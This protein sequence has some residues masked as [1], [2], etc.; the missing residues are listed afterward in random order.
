MTTYI[1][2][3]L[4]MG[5]YST[6]LYH[7]GRSDYACCLSGL[8]TL[9]LLFLC[10][11]ASVSILA[12]TFSKEVFTLTE[13]TYQFDQ[14]QYI[15][16]T[17]YELE[18]RGLKPLL[19]RTAPVVEE[20]FERMKCSDLRVTVEFIEDFTK[21]P[22]FNLSNIPFKQGVLMNQSYCYFDISSEDVDFQDIRQLYLE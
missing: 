17:I 5:Q 7:K 6:K 21:P 11:F 3:F 18:Q 9:A 1:L 14:T 10:L 15:N 16:M 2:S 19:L 4:S 12:T 8:L 13:A 22:K 20:I